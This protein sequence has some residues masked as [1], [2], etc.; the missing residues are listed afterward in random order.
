MEKLFFRI[1]KPDYTS[2]FQWARRNGKTT[3]EYYFPGISCNI[4][5]HKGT[6]TGGCHKINIDEIPIFKKINK[7]KLIKF[8]PKYLDKKNLW[9]VPIDFFYEMLRETFTEEDI[10]KYKDILKPGIEFGNRTLWISYSPVNSFLFPVPWH[11]LITE[12]V[13]NLLTK[14]KIKNFSYREVIMGNKKIKF[15]QKI[16]EIFIKKEFRY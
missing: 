13:L 16:Y 14:N 10:Q 2:D 3:S 7:T 12:D 6:V 5:K 15:E 4:C 8:S 1:T 11:P 9:N